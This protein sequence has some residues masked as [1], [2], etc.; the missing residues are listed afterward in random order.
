MVGTAEY[1]CVCETRHMRD[2]SLLKIA[3]GKGSPV[4][5]AYVVVTCSYPR[6][7]D[8]TILHAL[9]RG[10]RSAAPCVTLPKSLQS[11]DHKI[12]YV[13]SHNAF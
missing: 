12:L 8:I 7:P 6:Y 2:E 4:I 1:F 10:T 13:R 3:S 9:M 11:D 5:R